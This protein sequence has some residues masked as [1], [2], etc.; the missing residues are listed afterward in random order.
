MFLIISL[1]VFNL[2]EHTIHQNKVEDISLLL[3]QSIFNE[4][5]SYEVVLFFL[6]RLYKN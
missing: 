5:E 3:L 4:I 2:H 1:V 6:L